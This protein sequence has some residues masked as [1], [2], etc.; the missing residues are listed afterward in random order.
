MFVFAHFLLNLVIWTKCSPHSKLNR[1]WASVQ[2]KITNHPSCD[3]GTGSV[4][5]SFYFLSLSLCAYGK[6]RK[7]T[8]ERCNDPFRAAFNS[9]KQILDIY[10]FSTFESAHQVEAAVTPASHYFRHILIQYNCEVLGQVH[11]GCS[12]VKMVNKAC[13]DLGIRVTA[14][15]VFLKWAL[16][17]KTA[18]QETTSW[19]F[20]IIHSFCLI[21]WEHWALSLEEF[22]FFEDGEVTKV[23][24]WLKREQNS[25]YW[26]IHVTVC[27]CKLF[28]LMWYVT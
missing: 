12:S 5:F 14:A 28:I 15:A 6:C 3:S 10:L 16:A 17:A 2:K 22:R 21:I 19:L 9:V 25:E 23:H 18:A 7:I 26:G 1:S 27:Q 8:T 20:W 24:R 4:L 11:T 13:L